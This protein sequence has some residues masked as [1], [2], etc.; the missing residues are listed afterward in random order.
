MT[1]AI[2][3]V[4]NFPPH[5]SYVSTLLDITQKLECDNDELKHWHL[6]QYSSGPRGIIDKDIDQWQTRLRA[7]V[8][9]KGRHFKHLLWSRHTTGSFQPLTRQIG[10]FGAT[11]THIA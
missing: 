1:L 9:A 3:R 2:K 6:G 4:H 10:F 8:K 5:L 7:R 11:H